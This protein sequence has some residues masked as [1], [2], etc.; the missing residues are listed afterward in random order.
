MNR[1]S[2]ANKII[3]TIASNSLTQVLFIL[4]QHKENADTRWALTEP[5]N[6][7]RN[8]KVVSLSML[9]N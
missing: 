4:S 7:D 2:M 5:R 8:M 3:E 1:E 6:H 9:N